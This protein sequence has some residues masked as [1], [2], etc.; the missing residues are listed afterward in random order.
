MEQ[1][2]LA[3]DQLAEALGHR[4]DQLYSYQEQL[5]SMASELLLVE[6]RERRR[7]AVE[8]HDQVGHSLAM[9]KIGLRAPHRWGRRRATLPGS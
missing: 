7:I 2:A 5:R 9:A 8:L 4:T 3:L 1:I 6:E